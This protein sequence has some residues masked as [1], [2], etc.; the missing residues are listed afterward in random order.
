M[1]DKSVT[2]QEVS[3]DKDEYPWEPKDLYHAWHLV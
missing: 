2:I 3:Y 1:V